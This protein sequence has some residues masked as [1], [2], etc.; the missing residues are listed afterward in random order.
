MHRGVYSASIALTTKDSGRPIS[1]RRD[2]NR[3]C[4][5]GPA[6]V[7]VGTSF[8]WEFE[9]PMATNP[10]Y[11][12]KPKGKTKKPAKPK[13]KST[14]APE[15]PKPATAKTAKPKAA[16]KPKRVRLTAEERKERGRARTAE[17]RLKLKESGLCRDCRQPAIP[18]QTRCPDCAEKHRTGG[19]P[20][21]S[22]GNVQEHLTS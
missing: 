11:E 9:F 20:R 16:K 15:T 10:F 5:R 8:E 17:K 1:A 4:P 18:G 12:L 7:A 6:Q 21:Q 3:R 2:S 19:G 13:A 14:R 22:N